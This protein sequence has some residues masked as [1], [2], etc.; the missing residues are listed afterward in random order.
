MA[1]EWH[2]QNDDGS[3]VPFA[4]VDSAMIETHRS[5]RKMRY[6]TTDLSFNAHY[7]TPYDFDLIAS[8]QTNTSSGKVRNLRRIDTADESDDSG[9]VRVLSVV[10]TPAAAA[11]ATIAVTSTPAPTASAPTPTEAPLKAHGCRLCDT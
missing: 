3:W 6:T 11:P 9:L 7:L 2:W 5:T 4:P 10:A 1:V 8:T